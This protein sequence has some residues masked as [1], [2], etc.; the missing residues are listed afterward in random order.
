MNKRQRLKTRLKDLVYTFVKERDEYTC[1]WCE[2]TVSH[3]N[4]QASHVVSVA[5]DGRLAHDPLNIKVLCGTCHEKWGADTVAGQKWFQEL[6]PERW[7]HIE[8]ERIANLSKG[9]IPH[10]WFEDKIE[11]F[12]C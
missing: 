7:E 6:F 5:R 8:R 10:S 3:N 12:K 9:R 4:C 1:Q 2:K 11:E